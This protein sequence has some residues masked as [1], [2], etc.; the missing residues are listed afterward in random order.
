VDLEP[1]VAKIVGDASN[2]LREMDAVHSKM[3]QMENDVRKTKRSVEELF[4]ANIDTSK[5]SQ[6]QRVI[7]SAKTGAGAPAFSGASGLGPYEPSKLV[8]AERQLERLS[9]RMFELKKSG[10]YVAGGPTEEGLARRINNLGRYVENVKAVNARIDEGYTKIYKAETDRRMAIQKRLAMDPNQFLEMTPAQRAMG[11]PNPFEPYHLTPRE[12]RIRGLQI[13]AYS[14]AGTAYKA[15]QLEEI[16]APLPLTIGERPSMLSRI[17]GG[18]QVAGQWATKPSWRAGIVTGMGLGGLGRLLGVG[19]R[20][21]MGGATMGGMAAGPI[22]AVAGGIGGL[23]IDVAV[24]GATLLEHAFMRIVGLAENLL[25]RSISLGMEWQNSAATFRVLTGSMENADELMGRLRELAIKTPYTTKQYL[26]EAQTLLGGG[27]SEKNIP[28]ILNRLGD[29]AGGD[30]ERLKRLTDIFTQ[31]TTQGHLDYQLMR[32]LRTLGLGPADLSRSLGMSQVEFQAKA[33]GH[34]ISANQFIDALNKLTGPGGRFF[35]VQQERMKTVPGA[36]SN[37]EETFDRVL[38]TFTAGRAGVTGGKPAIAGLFDRLGVAGGIEKLTDALTGLEERIPEVLDKVVMWF[39]RLWKLI[40]DLRPAAEAT[41]EAIKNGLSEITGSLGI[42][43]WDEFHDKIVGWANELPGIIENKVVPAIKG[44]IKDL[45]RIIAI[46]E[47]FDRR[48]GG[49]EETTE[50]KAENR[51]IKEGGFLSA[52]GVARN[53]FTTPAFY[54]NILKSVFEETPTGRLFAGEEGT[55]D[56]V[57]G[58]KSPFRRFLEWTDSLVGMDTKYRQQVHEGVARPVP[59]SVPSIVKSIDPFATY[60]EYRQA[61]DEKRIREAQRERI[62]RMLQINARSQRIAGEAIREYEEKG[63]SPLD[64]F[65]IHTLGI[66]EALRGPKLTEQKGGVS[67]GRYGYIPERGLPEITPE[68]AAA[69]DFRNFVQLR[70]SVA[71]FI[72]RLPPT[73]MAGTT[74]AQDIIARSQ[75]EQMT[76]Q[77]EIAQ[78]LAAAN[79]YHQGT[80]DAIEQ[81][82]AHAAEIRAFVKTIRPGGI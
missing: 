52:E 44:L 3:L 33:Q 45:E 9:K 51:R 21:A 64:L 34:Q 76:I 72:E 38:T 15:A 8:L 23:G 79:V 22:G 77:E 1:V 80:K 65:A 24:T 49:K 32:R 5:I 55:K 73:A 29:I 17:A 16:L 27:I 58:S 7:S 57:Q 19:G 31:V 62:G 69:A 2:F 11:G 14:R 60:M 12:R 67:I 81:I 41:W 71:P 63:I 13:E 36:L 43:T 30:P 53:P 78:T 50:E 40:Q 66:Q 68:A 70:Q 61:E 47:W 10:E 56:K 54:G 48:T 42:K 18:A 20:F 46:I 82:Q 6:V 75:A 28:A 26:G 35:G 4:S 59:T 37:L 74:E 39:D 25:K